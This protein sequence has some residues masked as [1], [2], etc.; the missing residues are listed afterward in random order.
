[1]AA[2]EP[3]CRKGH[4][5]LEIEARPGKCGIVTA[6]PGDTHR[7]LAPGT[8]EIL[9]DYLARI[10]RYRLLTREEEMKLSGRAKAGGVEGRRA[11]QEL[12]EK[13]LRLVVSVAKRYRWAPEALALEDLIQEGNMG[14]IRA[15]EKFDPGRGYR[16]STY[17]VWWI[18]Q[19]I[20][21]AIADKGR[22]IRIP[23]HMGEKI[24]RVKR[25]GT[26]LAHKIGRQPTEE[27][28]AGELGW[29]AESVEFAMG[30]AHDAT[31]LDKPVGSE[32]TAPWRISDF[33]EDEEASGTPDAV[34]GELEVEHL[35]AAI[36]SLPERA[37]YV[38]V[39]RYGL[40]DGEP[41]T[42]LALGA[43]LGVPPEHVRRLQ[44]EAERAIRCGSHAPL[45]RGVVV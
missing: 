17:A 35:K 2:H 37:R 23:V 13:N 11:R 15:A 7:H 28:I 8:P 12:I 21:R 45:L 27:E 1:L 3:G 38:L 42:L 6:V 22:T 16:F 32:D 19:A 18:R 33:V 14:L 9:P 44:R 29:D 20:G 41:A 40:D 26:E 24:S 43:E 31:S 30:A 34:I 4:A 39:R 36:E 5:G 25:T 10:G